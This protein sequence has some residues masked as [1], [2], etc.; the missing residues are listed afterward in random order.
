ML[1]S[2]LYNQ[3]HA[4][5]AHHTLLAIAPESVLVGGAVR[6]LVLD[7]RVKD[8]DY[9]LPDKALATARRLANTLGGSYYPL[10][11]ARQIGRVVWRCSS[12]ETLSIDVSLTRDGSLDADLVAR[13]FTLNAI[14]LLPNGEPYDPLGGQSDLDQRLLRTCGARSL[15]QDP[16]RILRA[17][18]FLYT[19]H[20]HPAAGLDTLVWQASPG[21]A[22]VSPERQRDELFKLFALP[23]P[24]FA[25]L[26]MHSWGIQQQLFPALAALHDMAQSPPHIY[27]GYE[28]SL[29]ALRAM[30]R[31]DR[32]LRK[33]ITPADVIET[34]LLDKLG[35]FQVQ[36]DAYLCHEFVQDRPRWLWLRF[37]ALAHD[38]GKPA[39]R[40]VEADGRIRFIG[41]EHASA[42]LTDAWM[43]RYHC[44]TNEMTFV[45][46]VCAGHMRPLSLSHTGLQPSRRSIYRFYRDLGDAATGVLLLHMA[47]Y[48]ATYGP[49]LAPD[50]LG[51][52]MDFVLSLMTP[53]FLYGDHGPVPKSL[54]DGKELMA[55]L[56]LQPGPIIGELLEQLREAQALGMIAD[57]ENAI[58]YVRQLMQAQREGGP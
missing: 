13:D 41:H 33:D 58:A 8:L 5:K 7:R 16:I 32:L 10:D 25:F 43:E 56:A 51:T 48:L 55:A 35:P 20:L 36:L 54:L 6:D 44:A 14:A 46:N 11:A 57:R 3:P 37:A 17:I 39:V 19:F 9:A 49:T 23:D 45:H 27:N 21:L 15:I 4:L 30:A 24:H 50:Q 29:M 12:E 40:T 18:R 47:D 42:R 26:H 52:H 38:W 34:I 28:H 31:I 22:R 1:A 2:R 53:A